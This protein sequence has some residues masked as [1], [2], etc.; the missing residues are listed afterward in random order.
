MRQGR[1]WKWG[2]LGWLTH[3]G[4]IIQ[5]LESWADE[6]NGKL[7]HV[8]EQGRNTGGPRGREIVPELEWGAQTKWALPPGLCLWPRQLW[9]EAL[10]RW[11]RAR[12]RIPAGCL[13]LL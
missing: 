2:H 10:L 9:L 3:G 12:L 5:G 4:C 7:W 1:F 6:D 11:H 13:S 8:R